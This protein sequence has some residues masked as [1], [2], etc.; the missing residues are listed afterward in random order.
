MGR[1]LC[2]KYEVCRNLF[3]RAN[4]VLQRDLTKICF[5]GPEDV[6]TKT[7]NAQ[8]AIFLHS[9]ACL[10]AVGDLKFEA[11][12]GLSLGEFT[13]LAAAGAV[14]FEDGL[15]MVQARGEFMQEAC[16]TTNGGMASIIGL[17]E[18][19]VAEVCREAGVDV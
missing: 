16:D 14:T 11:T 7:D 13:A 4:E 1:D 12:A 2:E 17:E 19:V 9:L 8:P 5:E 15:K 6:L 3:A 18:A 10:A